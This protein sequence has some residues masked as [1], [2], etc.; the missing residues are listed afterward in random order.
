[1]VRLFKRVVFPVAF[2]LAVLPVP[3]AVWQWSVPVKAEKP[4]NG[5][6][7][8]WLWIPPQCDY[9]R[10]VVIAQDNMEEISI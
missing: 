5:P 8:A 4:P 6:A 9:V 2:L 3:A 10:G 7:R 1:M